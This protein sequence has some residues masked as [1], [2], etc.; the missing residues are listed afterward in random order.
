[1]ARK[2]LPADMIAATLCRLP[3]KS[4]LRLRCLSKSWCSEIDSP[5]F[6]QLHLQN[7]TATASNLSLV[8][9]HSFLSSVDLER[10]D[11]AVVKLDH[12]LEAHTF[13]TEILGCCNGLLALRNSDEEIAFWNPTTREH[14]ML[15]KA[16]IEPPPGDSR[17]AFVVYGFGYDSVHDDYKLVRL[18][19]FYRDGVSS[20]EAKV[21]SFRA[22]AWRGIGDFPYYLR[23]Q[24]CHGVL[25]NNA[26]HWVVGRDESR[27]GR[28]IVALDL[29]TQEYRLVEQ[30]DYGERKFH[31]NVKEL[32]GC[33]VI[34]AN[35][36]PEWVDLWVMKE[37]G[38]KESWTELV[39]LRQ[40]AKPYTFEFVLPVAYV[41]D[42]SKVLLVQ[43]NN[44]LICYDLGSEEVDEVRVEGLSKYF[45][46]TLLA[47]SLVKLN[48]GC[49]GVANA[50]NLIGA[51]AD[52]NQS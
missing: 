13:G 12:P 29:G 6:A 30:P 48:S 11:A 20:S 44:K 43:D 10:L 31:L 26:L 34:V 9:R 19:Q 3:A 51:G 1:M 25:V 27:G 45:E 16:E 52:E 35:Y 5:S 33:L 42:G 39:T 40:P 28:L 37:Y 36:H 15:P 38:V 41:G 23:Y 22:N 46:V 14:R 2:G 7:S 47:G 49:E 17:C 50:V 24:R 8:L 18:A 21:Y 4:L 32:G